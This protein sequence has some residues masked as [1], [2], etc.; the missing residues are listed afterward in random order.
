MDV[1]IE[2]GHQSKKNN[3][4][5]KKNVPNYEL[6]CVGEH[7]HYGNTGCGVFKQGYKIRTW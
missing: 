3:R 1:M 4:K 7:S 6:C 5:F 2:T